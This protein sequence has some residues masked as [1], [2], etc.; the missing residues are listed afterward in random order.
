MLRARRRTVACLV[1][2]GWVLPV[3]AQDSGESAA[4]QF[5]ADDGIN[6]ATVT[7]DGLSIV[8]VRGISPDPARDRAQRIRQQIERVAADESVAA[9]DGRLVPGQGRI[10][11]MFGEHE[12]VTLFDAD[13]E[14]EA[15][16]LDVL[17]EATLDRLR[18]AIVVY[19]DARSAEPLLR[20]T[21]IFAGVTLVAAVV[22]FLV[23]KLFGWLAH[24]LDAKLKVRMQALDRASH[25]VLDTKQLGSWSDGLLRA[26]R[27]ASVVAIVLTWLSVALG[28]Y[29]WTRP[30]ASS[31][32]RVVLDPLKSIGLGMLAA[33]P[34]IVFL[35]VLV[36]V[37][38]FILRVA[39]T[40]FDR[41]HRGWIRLANFDREWA[42]PTYRIL[43]IL[44]IAFALVVAYPYIPG[45][46]SDAFKGVSLFL[47]VIFSIGSSSFIGNIIAGYSL[48]YRRAF[49]PGDRVSIGELTGDVIES[50]MLSTR[51]KSIKNE[52]INIPNSTV[53]SSH[54]INYSSL[55]HDGGLVLHTRVGIG[56]D[57]P[58]RQ[59]EA[60]LLLAAGRTEGLAAEPPPFV[61]QVRLGDF[62][63]IYELNASCSD[64]RQMATLYSRLHANIQD[65]FSEYG[66]QIMSPAYEN[67]PDAPK[68]VRPDDWYRAPAIST[69]DRPE[70]E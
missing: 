36:F 67:D 38:R 18:R 33:I 13:A 7:V 68:L 22:L 62:A 69:A 56:Y 55:Q 35:V 19:R 47:G 20:A 28:I 50:R 3:G 4:R 12:A 11:L 37:V 16:P 65:V 34:D 53:L 21:A 70:K 63:V 64:A 61:L 14:L 43:R 49:R 40:F 45:S 1:L 25:R 42:L 39:R 23:L 44:I 27:F 66:V 51:L 60:L 52:E 2:A 9:A 24:L 48:T 15:V 59:V 41:V 30:F 6:A 8:R 58:W 29:P 31:V 26:L 32:Y 54:V 5:A 57:V 10:A 17:A 46:G